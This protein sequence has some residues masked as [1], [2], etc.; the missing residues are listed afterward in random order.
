MRCERCGNDRATPIN[1]EIRNDKM[2]FKYVVNL[3]GSCQCADPD[4]G[5]GDRTREI[6]DL[7]NS[8]KPTNP[9]FGEAPRKESDE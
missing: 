2:T 7:M 9:P 1:R 6:E 4:F 5:R 3:C 8:H